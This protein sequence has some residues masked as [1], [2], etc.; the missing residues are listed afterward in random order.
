[1]LEAIM[2][3]SAVVLLLAL[4][5][6]V[7]AAAPNDTLTVDLSEAIALAMGDSYSATILDMSL[8]QAK[9]EVAAAKGRFGTQADI[10]VTLPEL[11]EGVQRVQV[12][13]DLPR[14]DSYGSRE[15]RTTLQLKQ[16]LPTDGV[17]SLSGHVYQQNDTYYD[18]VL[19]QTQE[20]QTF[21]NSYDISLSQP[22]FA[23]NQLKLGLENAEINH[24]LARRAYQRG[25]LNLS[26]EVTAMF[27]QLIQAQQELIIATDALERQ[28]Q[29]FDLAQR[30]Y[31]AGLI[32]E[33]EAMQMEVDLA[34]AD[35]DLLGR[36]SDLILAVDRFRLLTGLPMT[37][38]V[39]ARTSLSPLLFAVDSELALQHALKHR[40]EIDDLQ[41]S[42][43]RSE[44][45]VIETDARSDLKG[46]LSAF[47]NLTGISDPTL[48]EA[49]IRDLI[50]SSWE[51][52][53]RRP[54]NRGIRLS[55]SLPLWDSGVNKQEVAAAEI[56][57]RRRLL[58]QENLRRDIV[59]QV[60][61]ALASFEGAKRR[62]QVLG[63]SQDIALRS[64]DISRQR[65]ETGDITSQAL[66]D[67]RDRLVQAK[68]S[69]LGA[70]VNYQLAGA[71]LRRLTLFDFEV[72]ESLVVSQ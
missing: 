14:Y 29:N 53:T 32:P 18:Q 9:H 43:R 22:L 28:Q 63:K 60:Q 54:G 55:L 25:Q 5:S 71:D 44:I 38:P 17:I 20:Q 36:E 39:R 65:F 68:R 46:E 21:F 50:D 41:D 58:D 37:Q 70:F 52:L 67:N 69:Y 64:Y 26:Y 16:P 4:S 66:A 7:Y 1:M 45:T 51:D 13:G 10:Q 49:G 15:M 19:D 2:K 34:G 48:S 56:S 12:P 59:R 62:L 6:P 42:I 57:V 8:S 11:E 33:V 72:G 40:T 61:S 31:E 3:L 30:K 47:Y 24:R 35:N 23:P 27:Y